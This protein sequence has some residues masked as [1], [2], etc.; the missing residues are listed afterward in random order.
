M[1]AAF[2]L[3]IACGPHPLSLGERGS[4]LIVGF[5]GGWAPSVP[6]GTCGAIETFW[7]AFCPE[8]CLLLARRAFSYSS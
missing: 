5:K 6:L 8:F 4:P 2:A 3:A 7:K 1:F